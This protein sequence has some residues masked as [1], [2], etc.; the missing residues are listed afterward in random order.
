VPFA[1]ANGQRLYYEVKGEG[2]PLIMISGLATDHLVWAMQVPAIASHFR[3]VIFDNRD[4]GRSSQAQGPYHITHMAGDTIALADALELESFHLVGGSMGGAIAQE[5]ALSSPQRVRTLTLCMTWGGAG[6]WGVESSRLWAAAAA[7]T[8]REELVDSMMLVTLSEQFYEDPDAVAYM[9]QMTMGNPHAQ[10]MEAFG[11]QIQACGHHETRK[12]LPALKMP[13]HVIG[14]ECDMLIP[15]WKSK[16]L[17][18]LIPGARLTVLAGASHAAG[19]EQTE[20]YNE[21]LLGFLLE[22][23]G[24]ERAG[25]RDGAT[26]S[27]RGASSADPARE[28]ATV[29]RVRA[30]GRPQPS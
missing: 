5:V 4:S 24:G 1:E 25:E 7:R 9:R 8:P 6:T 29:S 20:R 26:A 17:A 19:I 14:G 27:R 13:V 16:E 12:R 18:R 28:P 2:E 23:S 10:S 21:A 22:H 3:T 30:A 15:V 11:R